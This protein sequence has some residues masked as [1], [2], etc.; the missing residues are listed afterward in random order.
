M[1]QP[2]TYTVLSTE[3]EIF[4]GRGGVSQENHSRGFIPAFYDTHSCP[5]R[6]F[7]FC[8]WRPGAHPRIGRATRGVGRGTG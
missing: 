8:E 7:A 5:G 1:N 3:N 4:R 6:G 2:L